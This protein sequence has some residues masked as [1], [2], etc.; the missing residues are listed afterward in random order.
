MMEVDGELVIRVV[1]MPDDTNPDGDMFGGW[2]L[3]QMDLGA[4]VQ[5][6]K[7][8]HTKIVTV[9]IDNIVFHKLVFVGDC[10]L[11]YATTER[12]GRTSVT[13]KIDAMMERKEGRILEQVMEGRFVF[14]AIGND[15][16]PVTVALSNPQSAGTE[17]SKW[18]CVY[19]YMRIKYSWI[20]LPSSVRTLK[21]LSNPIAPFAGISSFPKRLIASFGFASPNRADAKAI[22]RASSSKRFPRSSWR[23]RSAK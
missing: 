12:I 4:Y 6:R 13:V 19:A 7:Y 23:Q 9:A 3:S 22:S 21:W 16:K 10:L 11:C 15:R 20:M 5:A 14:V 2:V 17:S 1:A 18:A 8:T